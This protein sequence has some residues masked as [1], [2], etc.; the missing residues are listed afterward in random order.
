MIYVDTNIFVYAIENHPRFGKRCKEI[1]G[2]VDSKRLEACCSVL[3]L[4]ELINVLKK[5]NGIL[6][7][8]GKKRLSIRDNIEAVLSLPIVWIDMDMAVIERASAYEFSVNGVDYVHIAS[9][10]LTSVNEILS[11]DED[12]DSVRVIVRTDPLDYRGQRPN[13]D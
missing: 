11:A 13:N 10:E 1:L 5:I 4:V 6:S 9:M 12:L 8:E 2:D 3:V 7:K